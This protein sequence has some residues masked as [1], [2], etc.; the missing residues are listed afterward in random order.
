MAAQLVAQVLAVLPGPQPIPAAAKCVRE[1]SGVDRV[2]IT[3]IDGDRYQVLAHAGNELLPAGARFALDTSTHFLRASKGD[4]FE[5]ID[6]ASDNGFR[7]PLDRLVVSSGFRSGLSVPMTVGERVVGALSLSSSDYG[8]D[9]GRYQ[10]I[11]LEAA[12]SVL[13][14]HLV[15]DGWTGPLSVLIAH[16]D[17]LVAAGIRN[18]LSSQI[19]AN[20]AIVEQTDH[21][22]AAILLSKPDVVI[23]GEGFDQCGDAVATALRHT[24]THVPLVFLA[25]RDAPSARAFAGYVGASAFISHQSAHSHLSNVVV[26]LARKEQIA[27]DMRP[28]TACANNHT[29]LTRREQ[30][31]LRGLECGRP[32]RDIARDLGL[33]ETT[34]KG[35]A[36]DLY[37][38]LDAH[39]RGE[40][41]HVA[42][43]RGLLA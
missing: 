10:R 30:D 27:P 26:S 25:P 21:L 16:T 43:E 33:S 18:V 9:P 23:V 19:A 3:A 37:A 28:T 34:L 41:V 12:A 2:S 8:W 15:G 13:A 14:S 17:A 36:R 24:D 6:F 20:A 4:E 32:L 22:Q 11:E 42:R 35:Y 40:A 1:Y 29:R 5:C 31:L 7:R 38:K 39:S